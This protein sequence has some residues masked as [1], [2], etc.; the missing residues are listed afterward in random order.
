MTSPYTPEFFKTALGT[1]YASARRIAP[2]VLAVVPARSMLDVGCGT[3]HFLRAFREAGVNEITGI[4]GDHVP[5]DLLVIER[6]HFVT[7]DLSQGFDL[8][9]EYELVVSLE[10]AEHLPPASAESFIASLVRH[11]PVT[12]FSAAIPFQGGTAHLNERWPSYWAQLFARHGY[13]AYD[14]LR[15]SIWRDDQVAWWYRQNILLFANTQA[16]STHPALAALIP[17]QGESL[18]QVHPDNYAAKAQ[19]W[20]AAAARVEQLE[21]LLSGGSLPGDVS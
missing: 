20:Q 10:V 2:L 21:A 5:R 4:D 16:C 9:R 15:P 19:G 3:G 18:D 17:T 1:S 14:I 6:E 13:R 7:C 11:A 8:K 12:V